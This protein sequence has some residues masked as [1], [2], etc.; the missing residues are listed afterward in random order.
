[1][2]VK[3]QK[4]FEGLIKFSTQISTTNLAPLDFKKDLEEK[5]GDSLVM[6]YSM[7]GNF[8]RIH[9][10]SAK[11]GMDSQLYLAKKGVLYLTDKNHNVD[12]L[13]V[14][15]NTLQLTSE[16]KIS[17]QTI[18]G[19]DCDCYEYEATSMYQQHVVLTYC[20]S[21]KTPRIDDNLYAKHIDFFL[22]DF[23][24]MSKRPY[25]KFSIQTEV[26]TITYIAHELIKQHLNQELF[27]LK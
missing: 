9:K 11:F 3:A 22:S 14:K 19:L 7:G 26:F 18:M 10:N 23:Y 24:K 17:S 25:L 1:M 13:N 15:I 12:S 16:R 6:Y 2:N 5:Y 20:Y 21:K 8:K 27:Q 4:N